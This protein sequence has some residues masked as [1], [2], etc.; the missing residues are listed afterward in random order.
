[1]TRFKDF[2]HPFLQKR[3]QAKVKGTSHSQSFFFL[4]KN[5]NFPSTFQFTRPF[6]AIV[7]ALSITPCN[8]PARWKSLTDLFLD[9]NPQEIT[10]S[11]H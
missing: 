5:P 10:Q 6:Y 1:M 4:R 3:V 8:D 2:V 9:L 7:H 11:K